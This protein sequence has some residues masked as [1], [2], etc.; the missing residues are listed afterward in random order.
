MDRNIGH[1]ENQADKVYK[2]DWR[3]GQKLK[4][5]DKMK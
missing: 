1:L 4:P 2:K 3:T 5:L